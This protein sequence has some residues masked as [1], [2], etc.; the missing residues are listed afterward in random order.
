[1]YFS[2]QD[3]SALSQLADPGRTAGPDWSLFSVPP[4]GLGRP[5][6]PRRQVRLNNILS[7][8]CVW[9]SARF[10]G[11]DP[12]YVHFGRLAKKQNLMAAPPTQTGSL[13]HSTQKLISFL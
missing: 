9:Q 12:E 6:H 3:C 1:M 5:R 2:L 10:T 4:P 13:T 11:L 8:E 7:H